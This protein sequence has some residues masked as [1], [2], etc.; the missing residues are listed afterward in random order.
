MA[1]PGLRKVAI[2]S[3]VLRLNEAEVSRKT[4]SRQIGSPTKTLA[5]ARVDRLRTRSYGLTA[6][7]SPKHVS[8]GRNHSQGARTI[9]PRQHLVEAMSKLVHYHGDDLR[10]GEYQK[11]ARLGVPSKTY[12]VLVSGAGVSRLNGV[13]SQAICP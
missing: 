10:C 12:E 9:R 1:L 2:V 5:A 3:K 13:R 11:D 7:H 8:G 6:V 4:S